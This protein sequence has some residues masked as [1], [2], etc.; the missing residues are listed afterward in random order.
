MVYCPDSQFPTLGP[1][2][3]V[4]IRSDL[5][6]EPLM[7]AVKARLRELQPGMFVESFD[8]ASAIS[9]GFVGQRLMAM[10]AGFFGV[11]AG[12]GRGGRD[13]WHGGLRSRAAAARV[14]RPRRARRVR[15][16]AGRHGH[17]P[18]RPLLVVGLGIGVVLGGLAGRSI[19]SMLFDI[20]PH[21]PWILGGGAAL[22]AVSALVASFV[23]ARRA[24]RV[25][26]LEALRQD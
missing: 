10:L 20:Q 25:N 7:R 2:S 21:D 1:W 15:V 16:A 5:P 6:S 17:A 19:Q 4:M 9:D 18:G 12:A 24:A 13:L 14:G 3:T 8:F 11:V 22:L 23:P 26:P